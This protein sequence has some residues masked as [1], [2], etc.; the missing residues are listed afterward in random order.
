MAR[1]ATRIK[2]RIAAASIFIVASSALAL[3][4]YLWLTP[5]DVSR[6]APEIS[7]FIGVRTG[8]SVSV[9]SVIVRFLPYPDIT[10][11]GLDISDD[12]GPFIRS[13]T[14]RLKVRY[15]PLL[16]RRLHI[17]ALDLKGATI[18]VKKYADST[19][20][21]D[22][23]LMGRGGVAARS[24][25]GIKVDSARL[26][27]GTLFFT[28]MATPGEP[29]FEIAGLRGIVST[30]KGAKR[31][32]L[33]GMLV[34]G[35]KVA[36][37]GVL[38]PDR[39]T[40]NGHITAFALGRLTPYAQS[41]SHGASLRGKADAAFSYAHG[42]DREIKVSLSYTALGLGLPEIFDKN[43][44]SPNGSAIVSARSGKDSSGFKIE[45]ARIT[46]PGF[47][48]TGFL[49][50]DGSSEEK[51]VRAGFTSTPA[52]LA[53]LAD[54]IPTKRLPQKTRDAIELFTPQGGS[55]TIKA[56]EID[57]RLSD[58]KSALLLAMPPVYLRLGLNNL[59]FRVN[60]FDEPFSGISGEVHLKGDRIVVKDGAARYGN[61]TVRSVNA[62][63]TDITGNAA[64]LGAAEGSI[65]AEAGLA[66][67][68]GIA[69][70]KKGTGAQM[71]DKAIA[72]GRIDITI[73]AGG[74]FKDRLPQRYSGSVF[75]S[76]AS[77]SY[78]GSP[79]S[80]ESLNADA[81]FDEKSVL[82][83]GLRASDGSSFMVM[84][85]RISDYAGEDPSFTLAAECK[86]DSGTVD[87]I[88]KETSAAGELY[89]E[90]YAAVKLT[91]QGTGGSAR[92]SLMADAT[93]ARIAYRDY[94]RKEEYFP[95][96]ITAFLETS[97][98]GIAIKKAS[99]KAG[100]S[101]IELSGQMDRGNGSYDIKTYS[102]ELLLEDLDSVS[103]YL[104]SEYPSSGLVSFEIN[105]TR[106]SQ[107]TRPSYK[108]AV[109]VTSGRFK[110]PFLESAVERLDATASFDGH[111]GH[112][113]IDRMYV[114]RS[115]LRG[116]VD[117]DDISGRKI[118]FNLASTHLES[119]DLIPK[120]RLRSLARRRI[121]PLVTGSGTI[122]IAEGD[123]WGHSFKEM[124]AS[125]EMEK[126]LVHFNPVGMRIDGGNISAAA[127]YHRNDEDPL[128]FEAAAVASG[129]EIEPML[130]AFGVKKQILAG[131]LKG[132]GALWATRGAQPFSSGLNGDLRLEA[133]N[134]RL[135]KFQVMAGIFSVVNILSIDELFEE[136]LPYKT[137]SGSFTVR[138]GMIS[139]EDMNLDSASL[140]MSA[141]GEIDLPNSSINGVLA[142]HPLVTIDKIV[143]NIPLA[144]Y[145]IT[146]R[147]ESTASIYFGVEG[148]LKEAEVS[149]LPVKSVE[150]GVLGILERLIK[151]PIRLL[152]N[153]ERK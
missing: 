53:S 112:M 142:M 96:A 108:G 37:D 1:E 143:S 127:S 68:K 41:L 3:T 31:F 147:N 10:I 14:L 82:I 25:F 151:T 58:L 128:L 27:S 69:G 22:D 95:A 145:I 144:G 88:I 150:E 148:P 140:R 107:E 79:I 18:R 40:G 106:A 114:G 74:R 104:R 129:I 116:T 19:T 26:E 81:L 84:N 152:E 8:R 61:N 136:G 24:G 146:G 111:A 115:D 34:P 11:K 39:I 130:A 87:A 122:T 21:I 138:D 36:L 70:E 71:L 91:A 135:W 20:N 121:R 141:S 133:D 9:D 125:I 52:P 66:I 73:N 65:E 2:K 54:L 93:Q 137:L 6:W 13:G 76:D 103:P 124:N 102:H 109:T 59:Q 89:T 90:G 29:S 123:A 7:S 17:S 62:H 78:P 16:M 118:R 94:I 46:L 4:I 38:G 110:T 80:I 77:L 139:T 75:V 86:I 153:E 64:Y 56:M 132:S 149:L 97:N 48:L 47:S 101:A 72:S 99:V 30:A 44:H 131:T 50:V 113:V 51:T 55:V 67:A 134:G 35:T 32:E 33:D 120:E 42:N 105:A 117:I 12:T 83:T 49:T 85:G 5:V 98:E 57:A 45:D 23:L 126:D 100:S 119:G 63:L 43:I 15:L 28:D 60:G 92:I